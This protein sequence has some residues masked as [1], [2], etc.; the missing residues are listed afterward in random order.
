MKI[1]HSNTAR[2]YNEEEWCEQHHTGIWIDNEGDPFLSTGNR[3]IFFFNDGSFGVL[4]SPRFPIH[5][6]PVGYTITITQEER[7]K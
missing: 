3:V 1:T 5:R 7:D 2:Q 4:K 6:A